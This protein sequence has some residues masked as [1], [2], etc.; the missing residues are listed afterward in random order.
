MI[1]SPMFGPAV[2]FHVDP[3]LAVGF[4]TRF[5]PVFSTSGGASDFGFLVQVLLAYKM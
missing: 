5:G 2:E 1:F 4:N 3:R